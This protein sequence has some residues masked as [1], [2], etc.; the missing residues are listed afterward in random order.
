MSIAI[1]SILTGVFGFPSERAARIVA[2]VLKEYLGNLKR[3]VIMDI[4][5]SKLAIYRKAYESL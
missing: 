2:G 4:D 3:I 5:Q 1:P